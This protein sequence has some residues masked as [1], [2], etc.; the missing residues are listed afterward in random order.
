MARLGIVAAMFEG[1]SFAEL[2]ELAREAESAGFSVTLEPRRADTF[3]SHA[4]E[5]RSNMQQTL[6]H[7]LMGVQ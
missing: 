5:N 7:Y 1:L 6:L 4:S 3:V 2:Q